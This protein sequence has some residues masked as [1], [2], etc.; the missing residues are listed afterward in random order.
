L[1]AKNLAI[2]SLVRLLLIRIA[3]LSSK[4][5]ESIAVNND[6]LRLF[7]RF[8]DLVEE[9]YRKHWHLPQYTD[10]MGVSESRLNQICQRISNRSPK[11]LIHDRIVQETKRLLTFSNLGINEICFELGFADPAYFSRFFKKHAGLTAQQY[12][13]QQQ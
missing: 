11:K 6:D 4:R 1:A 9:H 12:R 3:R 2:D 13:K 8:S 7:H 10:H 5:A